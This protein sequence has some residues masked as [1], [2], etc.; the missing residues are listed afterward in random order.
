VK[1]KLR[2]AFNS[3]HTAPGVSKDMI[4]GYGGA[5]LDR[6]DANYP[7]SSMVTALTKLAKVT[8]ELKGRM[9]EKAAQR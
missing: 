2:E 7:E 4:R 6:Y 8:D 1:V 9:L 3:V 5:K